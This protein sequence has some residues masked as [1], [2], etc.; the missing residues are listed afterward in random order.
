MMH[1][2]KRLAAFLF[3]ASVLLTTTAQLLFKAA[4]QQ[5]NGA[6]G[7]DA[8]DGWAILVSLPPSDIILL[9]IGL[10]C[11]ALSML[12][13]VAALSRF[14]VSV[15]YPV[16]SIS[17]VLVYLG[18]VYLPWLHESSSPLKLAG[19]AAIILGVALVAISGD[20]SSGETPG[21]AGP[22]ASPRDTP[23]RG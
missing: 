10:S 7:G 13:W 19:I 21:R 5:T 22:S 16:L 9:L 23:G 12:A 11:Y 1:V 3:A 8:P 18:A 20:D 15:A 14:D 17:Y 6:L 4:M 2:S